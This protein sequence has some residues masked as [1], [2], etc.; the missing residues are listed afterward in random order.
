MRDEPKPIA[1]NRPA[2]PSCERVTAQRPHLRC[3]ALRRPE[4]S[5]TS[6]DRPFLRSATFLS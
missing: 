5:E 1:P 3:A 4:T 2:Q 6:D